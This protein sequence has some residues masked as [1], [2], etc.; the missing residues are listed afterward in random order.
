MNGASF[1]CRWHASSG[2]YAGWWYVGSPNP[3]PPSPLPPN[4]GVLPGQMTFEWGCWPDGDM[5]PPTVVSVTTTG[6]GDGRVENGDAIVIQFSEALNLS[7]LCGGGG[8]SGGTLT[9]LADVDLN[10]NSSNDSITVATAG[11]SGNSNCTGNNFNFGTLTL[12]GNYISSNDRTFQ[13]STISWSGTTLTITLGGSDNN[14]TINQVGSSTMT[15]TPNSGI[16]DTSGNP[17]SG[18]GTS[19]NQ[20]W[21]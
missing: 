7:T 12:G 1:T 8:W 13:S 5:T 18:T 4:S 11:G 14:G 9:N 21:F 20:Q 19:A 16:Q 15:Y 6:D 3:H 10:N 2:I 17:I